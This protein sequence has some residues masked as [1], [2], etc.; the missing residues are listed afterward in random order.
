[1]ISK[2]NIGP[3][4]PFFFAEIISLKTHRMA[5]MWDPHITIPFACSSQGTSLPLGQLKC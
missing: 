5:R 4:P 3:W 2:Q 1:M